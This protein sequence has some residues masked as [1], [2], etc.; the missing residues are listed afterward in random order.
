[1]S[2][3]ADA[4]RLIARRELSVA[5]CRARLLDRNHPAEDVEA[6]LAR[7]VRDG[8]LDDRRAAHA[9]A[10]TALEVKGRGRVRVARELQERGIEREVAARALADV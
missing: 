5:E 9:H 4:L 7:L 1:M 2:A 6:A 8:A 10:R 3:Y